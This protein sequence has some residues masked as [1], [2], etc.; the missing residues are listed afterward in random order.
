MESG[1]SVE[2]LGK[3]LIAHDEQLDENTS[4]TTIERNS[5]ADKAGISIFM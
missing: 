1:P 5:V 4:Q 3:D 2:K